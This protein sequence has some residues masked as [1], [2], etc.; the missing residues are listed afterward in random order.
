M[1]RTN[2][3]CTQCGKENCSLTIIDD[4]TSVCDECLDEFYTQCD[5]CGEYWDDGYVEFF[6]LNDG[7]LICEHCRED[8]DDDEI[9]SEE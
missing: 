9:D 6:L 3:I 7:R 4:V 5:E 2:G 1:R 8:H